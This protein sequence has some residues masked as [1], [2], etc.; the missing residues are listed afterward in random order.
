MKLSSTTRVQGT[1]GRLDT[2]KGG[3]NKR[4]EQITTPAATCRH[5][6]LCRPCQNVPHLLPYFSQRVVIGLPLKPHRHGV[7]LCSFTGVASNDV[8]LLSNG[9]ISKPLH[10]LM[11]EGALL[12][13]KVAELH[14]DGNEGSAGVL[15]WSFQNCFDVGR[16]DLRLVHVLRL[17]L[18]NAGEGA[19]FEGVLDNNASL[20]PCRFSQNPSDAPTLLLCF[21]VIPRSCLSVLRIQS[22]CSRNAVILCN[23]TKGFLLATL[24]RPWALSSWSLLTWYFVKTTTPTAHEAFFSHVVKAR[25]QACVHFHQMF[26]PGAPTWYLSSSWPFFV[27]K[28]TASPPA[29]IS[30]ALALDAANLSATLP[31]VSSCL[32][33]QGSSSFSF[34]STLPLHSSSRLSFRTKSSLRL[35]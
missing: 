26:R 30:T 28:E 23:C 5:E 25:S 32:L 2:K 18:W 6:T 9:D 21:S 16:H 24:L 4:C 22:T 12:G 13:D 11:G 35:E 7:G 1:G 17:E 14:G 15:P 8:C 29:L 10:A 33:F 34:S 27:K 19:T 20:S 31:T 3:G